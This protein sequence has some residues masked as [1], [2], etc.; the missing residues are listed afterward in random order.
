MSQT[1]PRTS[2]QRGEETRQRASVFHV[3]TPPSS[4]PFCR[5]SQQRGRARERQR[6][7][8]ARKRNA[9]SAAPPPHHAAEVSACYFQQKTRS[10]RRC[11]SAC[12]RVRVPQK[13]LSCPPKCRTA[14]RRPGVNGG[15]AAGK[16]GVVNAAGVNKGVAGQCSFKAGKVY[17]GQL[18]RTGGR[19]GQW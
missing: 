7:Q 9:R 19:R 18:S 6:Q 4:Q 5:L 13:S 14:S 11:C 1:P 10:V 15:E 8:C 16:G 3:K 17:E 2:A 12:A